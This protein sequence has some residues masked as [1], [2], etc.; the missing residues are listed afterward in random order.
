MEVEPRKPSETA[1]FCAGKSKK[2]GSLLL[3]KSRFIVPVRCCKTRLLVQH[4]GA[5][6]CSTVVG[7]MMG[8]WIFLTERIANLA[9]GAWELRPFVSLIQI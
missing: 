9:V 3:P 6:V 5:N 4:V 1:K 8:G 2:R 7:K